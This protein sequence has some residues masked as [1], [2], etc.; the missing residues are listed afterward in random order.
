MQL[1]IY[2]LLIFSIY[3]T[4]AQSQ[5]TFDWSNKINC[6]NNI[7]VIGSIKADKQ[8]NTYVL[9]LFL[10]S[11][12]FPNG[13]L[14]QN[15]GGNYGVFLAKYNPLGG[16]IW[17]YKIDSV[18]N[19]TANNLIDLDI[20]SMGNLYTSVKRTG[21][22][23]YLSK[24]TSAGTQIWTKTLTPGPSGQNFNPVNSCIKLNKQQ[25]ELVITCNINGGNDVDLGN[26][27]VLTHSSQSNVILVAHFNTSNGN[28]INGK[29]IYPAIM[30]NPVGIATTNDNSLFIAL[31]NKSVIKLNY[32]DSTI[33]TKTI[34]AYDIS[35]I[36]TDGSNCFVI[37]NFTG[38][39]VQID[40][41][42]ASSNYL[43]DFYYAKIN[44][45]GQ[46]IFIKAGSIGSSG[47][48]SAE[49]IEFDKNK[50]FYIIGNGTSAVGNPSFSITS[51]NDHYILRYDTSG[52]TIWG[53]Q[54]NTNLN[55]GNLI[56]D[57]TSLTISDSLYIFVSGVYNPIAHFGSDSLINNFSIRDCFVF[58]LKQC[59]LS[60]PQITPSGA[61]TFCKGGSVNLTCSAAQKYLWSTGAT[62]QTINVDTSGNYSVIISNSFG[63]EASS[64][65][66]STLVNPNPAI[67]LVNRTGQIL[68]SSAT[69]NNQWLLNG[70]PITGAINQIYI[71]PSI[72][73]DTS[74]YAV[75]VTNG[76]DCSATSDTTCFYPSKEGINY[77]LNN[78]SFLLFPNPT[79]G[80]FTILLKSDNAKII[81]TDI[82]GRQIMKT[83]ASDKEIDLQLNQSGVY[84]IYIITNQ[85]TIISKFTVKN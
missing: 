21:L 44:S 60:Q 79:S 53:S 52:N 36:A 34:I 27:I 31:D 49:R 59:N 73:N 35:G 9:G 50:S 68:A 82:L 10:G 2:I 40:A 15:T 78:N 76:F 14:S 51:P 45:S 38:G 43:K 41:L 74:C 26:S 22:N 32:N 77:N 33:W 39:L 72:L 75:R 70:A 18:T 54:F 71:V 42:T 16:A 8:G 25:N 65:Y 80:K 55:T 24:Y 13:V 56:L 48:A 37:G 20:D 29:I 7:P 6:N 63:C 19:F 5:P 62:T 58:K 83:Q 67:P 1:K 12:A 47:N 61:T 4:T 23:L 84:F 81:I 57:R 30:T 85:E 3:F 66:I 69:S 11:I 64:Q 17:G 28:A 46:S